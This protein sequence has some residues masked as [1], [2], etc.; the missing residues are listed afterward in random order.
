LDDDSVFGSDY[1]QLVTPGTHVISNSVSDNGSDE[2]E[3]ENVREG[4][5]RV[6]V[7]VWEAIGSFPA[8]Q[9]HFVTCNVPSSTLLNWM[10]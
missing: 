8:L 2:Q 5:R 7:S 10:S 1:I 4:L 9:E 6:S 3:E